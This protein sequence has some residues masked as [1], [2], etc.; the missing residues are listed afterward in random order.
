MCRFPLY[1]P[2]NLMVALSQW[3]GHTE[4]DNSSRW[5]RRKQNP[6]MSLDLEWVRRSGSWSGKVNEEKEVD[7]EKSEN[8]ADMCFLHK[9][10]QR[11]EKGV[12]APLFY[13]S[14][15]FGSTEPN[16]WNW[17]IFVHGTVDFYW[18]REDTCQGNMSCIDLL[19]LVVP[20]TA[21]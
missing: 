21:C 15:V 16:L 2:L 6:L 12:F 14:V 5:W 9:I 4:I 11:E 13:G 17:V 10:C 7:I 3:L 18:A 8:S 19:I 20:K 1:P